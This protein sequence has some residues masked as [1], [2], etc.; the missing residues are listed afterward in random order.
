[1]VET[2]VGDAWRPVPSATAVLGTSSNL[3]TVLITFPRFEA[4]NPRTLRLRIDGR[5]S[6]SVAVSQSR[7]DATTL[8]LRLTV[9]VQRS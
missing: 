4:P 2:L 3:Y 9:T 5:E 7:E 1:M 6:K 8:H